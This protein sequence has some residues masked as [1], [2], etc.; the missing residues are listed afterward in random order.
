MPLNI[1][2]ASQF[3]VYKNGKNG[4]TFQVQNSYRPRVPFQTKGQEVCLTVK[5]RAIL[6]NMDGDHISTCARRDELCKELGVDLSL[7][8]GRARTGRFG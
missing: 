6:Q 5:T 1:P 2:Y 7:V 8:P 4:C 3:E